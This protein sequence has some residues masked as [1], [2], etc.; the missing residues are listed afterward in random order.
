MAELGWDDPKY[1]DKPKKLTAR[2]V[3]EEAVRERKEK[4]PMLCNWCGLPYALKIIP[5]CICDM[6]HVGR[7]HESV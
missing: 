7:H 1:K 6:W 4:P 2:Q 5:H 3:R